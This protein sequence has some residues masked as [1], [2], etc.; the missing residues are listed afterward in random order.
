MASKPEEANAILQVKLKQL[1]IAC[2]RTGSLLEV[3]ET[4]TEWNKTIE[5][6]LSNAVKWKNGRKAVNKRKRE[7]RS[8]NK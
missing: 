6:E 5:V 1:H 7:T 4:I 2:G 3:E 8:K